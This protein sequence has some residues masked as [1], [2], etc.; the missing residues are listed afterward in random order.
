MKTAKHHDANTLYLLQT[1]PGL[2]KGLS[3]VV[4]YAIHRIDRFP[5]VQE[6]AS[7]CRVGKCSQESGGKRWGSAGKKI[8]TAHRTWALSEAA[9]LF[10]RRHPQ[11]QKLLNRLEKKHAPG[12]AL[13]LLAHKLGRAVYFLLT[14]KVAFA[15]EMFLQTEGRRAGEP[16]A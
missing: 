5:S 7:S 1:V 4:R 14:R 16:G 10:L 6:F 15:M 11:G 3:L 13:S 8:G 12:K 9:T 2:G